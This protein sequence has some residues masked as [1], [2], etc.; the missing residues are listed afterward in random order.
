MQLLLLI[1][2]SSTLIFIV[3][4]LKRRFSIPTSFTRRILH[5]GTASVAAI[6]PIFVSQKEIILV[7]IIFAAALLIG[8]RYAVF[9]A[10]HSVERNTFG[11]AFLPLGVALTAL[12]FLPQSLAAFQ[13][14]ILV[15]GIADALAGFVGEKFGRH[16]ILFFGHKKSIEGSATFFLTSMAISF[17]YFPVFNLRLFLVPALLTLV[18]LCLVYGLDNLVLPVA[19]AYAFQGLF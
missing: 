8:R 12:L 1:L 17:L 9:S 15:M 3:E 6:A 16:T 18:E 2:A 14:G 11:E 5:A 13:F 4:V 7:S 19:G 10:I